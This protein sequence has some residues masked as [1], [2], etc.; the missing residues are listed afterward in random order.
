MDQKEKYLTLKQ[1]CLTARGA[2]KKSQIF[3]ELSAMMRDFPDIIA[4]AEAEEEAWVKL[5]AEK[6]KE[7]GLAIKNK[8]EPII[9]ILPGAY[10]AKTYFGK[11]GSWF[12]QRLNCLNIN[13]KIVKFSEEE[14][15]ALEKALHDI[16]Q[17]FLDINL[18][19][20]TPVED[21]V[22]EAP[23]QQAWLIPSNNNVF[24]VD[25][26]IADRDVIF[27]RQYNN[28]SVGDTVYIYGS[29]P[30]SRIKFE[31]IAEAVDLP[32]SDEVDD[33]E[34]WINE[35]EFENRAK[36]NRYM[37][38]RLVRVIDSETLHLEHLLE[39]GLKGAPQGAMRV[40]GELLDYIKGNA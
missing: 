18:T 23:I 9:D 19:D 3:S 35:D 22:P 8:L 5:Q 20:G 7:Q 21:N 17:K 1:E 14:I 25:D 10:I 26:C 39:H 34:Y 27:W 12:S 28:L 24:R 37:K 30:D 36:H 29:K 2:D 40:T 31:M 38:L 6:E 11:S 33:K 16:G 4:E 13:G 15:T 32:H